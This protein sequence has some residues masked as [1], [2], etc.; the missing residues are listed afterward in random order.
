MFVSVLLQGIAA[1]LTFLA[2]Y[3]FYW[4]RRNLPPGPIPLPLVGNILELA[5][6]EAWEETFLRWKKRYGDM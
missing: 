3:N 1:L 6:N 2:V 4:K 5:K